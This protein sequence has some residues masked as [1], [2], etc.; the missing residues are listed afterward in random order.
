[1]E[2]HYE[3][4]NLDSPLE[5]LS[6]DMAL[7]KAQ[8][9]AVVLLQSCWES[10][11][12]KVVNMGAPGHHCTSAAHTAKDGQLFDKTAV[13]VPVNYTVGH[14]SAASGSCLEYQMALSGTGQL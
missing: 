7:R 14:Q 11:V 5:E 9:A 3:W 4:R 12:P 1:M 6:R 10:S 2:T 8:G 13:C